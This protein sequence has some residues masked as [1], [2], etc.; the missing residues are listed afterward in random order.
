MSWLSKALKKTTKIID[1]V[2]A[3]LRKSTG[4]SYGDPMN[5]YNSKPNE[6]VPW[7]PTPSQGL[8]P[9]P[10]G[11]APQGVKLGNGSNGGYNYVPNQFSGQAAPPPGMTAGAAGPQAGPMKPPMGG[12]A[13]SFG[14]GQ[15]APPMMGSGGPPQQ[16]PQM[17]QAPAMQN[18]MAKIQAMRGRMM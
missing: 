3:K 15:A 8:M 1:P 14:G 16:I 4:G 11:P 6:T 9:A 7:Q 12:G 17:Q 5:W 18:Q 2:G 10:S 13:M